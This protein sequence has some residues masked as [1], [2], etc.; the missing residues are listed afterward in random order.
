MKNKELSIFI[1][2][3]F[4]IIETAKSQQS[5]DDTTYSTSLQSTYQIKH[6]QDGDK[7]TYPNGGD[8]ITVTYTG[9]IPTTG[10]QFDAGRY[11]FNIP[12]SVVKCWNTILI[13]MSLG[14]SIYFVCPSSTAYDTRGS[15]DGKIAPNTDIAFQVQLVCVKTNCIQETQSSTQTATTATPATTIGT[16]TT[17][18]GTTDTNKPSSHATHFALKTTFY[19]IFISLVLFL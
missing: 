10:T 8:S 16:A 19:I 4:L 7:K 6:L 1:I 14:E 18:K 9:T 5:Q 17:T 15:T 12:G 13:R 2:F 3:L 11:T